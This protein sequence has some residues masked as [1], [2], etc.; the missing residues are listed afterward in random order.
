MSIEYYVYSTQDKPLDRKALRDK[1][2][3]QGHDVL[4]LSDWETLT[5][6]SEGPLGDDIALSGP[7]TFFDPARI[8]FLIASKNKA[9]LERMAAEGDLSSCSIY[10]SHPF[11]DI[12]NM[13]PEEQSDM[14]EDV[15]KE[16]MD[17][18]RKANV[19]YTIRTSAGGSTLNLG[20]QKTIW[21]A[22]GELSSGLLEDPQSGFF[23][24]PK[25]L[26]SP[27][28]THPR[29]TDAPAN[30][31]PTSVA[32]PL[33]MAFQVALFMAGAIAVI[34]AM[35]VFEER[36]FRILSGIVGFVLLNTSLRGLYRRFE[37]RRQLCVDAAPEPD[38]IDRVLA[39]GHFVEN[40]GLPV[41]WKGKSWDIP[42]RELTTGQIEQLC[43]LASEYYRDD[44]FGLAAKTCADILTEYRAEKGREFFEANKVWFETMRKKY[45]VSKGADS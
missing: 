25:G 26:E 38:S 24:Y 12:R 31:Q 5:L 29:T 7:P 37:S 16:Q 14:E 42:T 4:L 19:H 21:Q 6:A 45:S 13:T 10:T 22:V 32:R 39:F 23:G 9:D 2:H 15:G 20:L 27:S 30:V 28:G 41:V 44:P 34:L 18:I 35:V 33:P 43:A 40:R 11:L 1:L 3:A 17:F 36:G 8:K